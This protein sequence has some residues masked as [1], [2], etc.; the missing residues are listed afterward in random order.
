MK[1]G[2]KRGIAVVM[3]VLIFSQIFGGFSVNAQETDGEITAEI[4][5]ASNV[6][7]QDMQ[8]YLD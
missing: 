8:T 5:V 4:T 3:A 6:S 2:W 1:K 7:K